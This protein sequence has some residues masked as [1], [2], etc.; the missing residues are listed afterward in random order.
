MAQCFDI[1]RGELC[2]EILCDPRLTPTDKCVGLRLLLGYMNNSHETAWMSATTLA[3]DLGLNVDTVRRCLG[4]LY[5]LGFLA[6]E[7]R[8]GRTTHY[9]MGSQW[10]ARETLGY[11]GYTPSRQE[12]LDPR[13]QRRPNL[14]RNQRNN[15]GGEQRRKDSR[16]GFGKIS[17][18]D[19][20]KSMDE[21][22][23]RE[24]D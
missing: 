8:T 7:R 14:N 13:R 15:L 24:E 2:T 18:K 5:K 1:R 16:H 9:W 10:Q 23:N 11:G 12:S 20:L 22:E 21:Q 3:N 4:R 6:R 17:V 19:M